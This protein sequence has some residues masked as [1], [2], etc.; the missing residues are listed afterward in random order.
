MA[1]KTTK[2]KTSKK[3]DEF[4]I[5]RLAKDGPSCY[6]F[7]YKKLAAFLDSIRDSKHFSW[8]DVAKVTEVSRTAIHRLSTGAPITKA[9]VDRLLR[10]AGLTK[11][12]AWDLFGVQA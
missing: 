10:F 9:S 3:R 1:K 4:E 12:A 5:P 6:S 11:A 2:T 7:N 8:A